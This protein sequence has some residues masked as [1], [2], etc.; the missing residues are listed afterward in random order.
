MITKQQLIKSLVHLK[1]DALTGNIEHVHTGICYNWGR[2]LASCVSYTVVG[3]FSQDWK[4]Y[5]G[6]KG[7]PVPDNETIGLWEGKNLEMRLSL[8]DHILKRLDEVDQ[9]YIDDLIG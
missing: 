3:E 2:L 8:I 9:D 5:S 1:Q 4:F 6:H 7:Y